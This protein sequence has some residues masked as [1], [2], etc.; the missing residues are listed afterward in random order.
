MEKNRRYQNGFWLVIA[1][2][3]SVFC[4]FVVYQVMGFAYGVADDVLMRDI[5]SGAFTGTPDG[6]LFFIRYA[7]GI[8]ISW[9]YFFNRNVDWYGF[10]IVGAVFLGLAMILYRGLS[11][12]RSWVWKTV[13]TCF[14]LEG[15]VIVLLQYV[16]WFQWT[17]SAAVL[18][19][20]ALYLYITMSEKEIVDKILIGILL[21]LTF[22]IRIN[23]FFMIMPGFGIVFLC[24]F[25][26]REEGNIQYCWKELI[27]PAAVFV[28]V[29][30]VCLVE[31]FAY[32]KAEWAEYG[33][34]Q[35]ARVQIYDYT[36]VPTFE[37]HMAFYQGIGLD[38]HGVRNLRHSAFYLIDNMDAKMLEQVS[39]ESK[40][41]DRAS[42][43]FSKRL[44]DGI[45]LAAHELIN[46]RYISVSAPAFLFLIA[47][48]VLAIRYRKQ[49]LI[50]LLIFWF[51]EGMQWLYLGYR[52]RL[53]DRVAFSL[54]LVQLLGT[55]AIFYQLL[56]V[57]KREEQLEIQRGWKVGKAVVQSEKRKHILV[58]ILLLLCFGTAIWQ[59]VK[60]SKTALQEPLNYQFF[61]D[62]CKED[63]DSFYFIE[64]CMAEYYGG[65]IV[66]THGDFRQNRCVTLGDW[67]SFSPLDQERFASLGISTVE[68]C[69]LTNPN[70]YLVV[71]DVE[72]PGFY[73]SY[74]TYKYPE[75][76]LVCREC[77][78]IKGQ[79]YYLYQVQR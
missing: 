19:A 79:N 27:L 36:G 51:L 14:V 65:A 25:F 17:V 48:L 38:E 57:A 67:Y 21:V 15:F 31:M 55:A 53:I 45:V 49:V 52:G 37:E 9:L 10:V 6:H 61:K 4:G 12:K 8:C 50:P 23:V 74:F 41:L 39:V 58:L 72:E 28:S 75:C 76:E 54:F 43:D 34:F 60:V 64:N 40:Q 46:L 35:D 2:I 3:F 77:R 16:V 18:G 63:V 22:L 26:Q 30:L 32:P 73:D 24:R 56:L 5:V 1:L 70:A 29:G 78:E 42:R 20:S 59:G 11:A 69:I 13:Y 71:R 68:E 44:K 33:R 66:T 62:S 7:L 47:C